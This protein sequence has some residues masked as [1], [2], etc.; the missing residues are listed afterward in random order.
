M[1]RDPGICGISLNPVNSL[2]CFRIV[3]FLDTNLSVTALAER[4]KP[5]NQ[6]LETQFAKF[7]NVDGAYNLN[8][9]GL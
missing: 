5:Q 6:S 7:M 9:C 3:T 2:Y 4:E 1:P 8:L